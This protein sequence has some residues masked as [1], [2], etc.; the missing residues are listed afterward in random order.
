MD[1]FTESVAPDFDEH[2]KYEECEYGEA[3]EL[4]ELPEPFEYRT[5]FT[6]GELLA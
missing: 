5:R 1:E 4:A 3:R 2:L 6:R